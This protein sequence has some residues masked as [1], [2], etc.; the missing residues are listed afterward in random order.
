MNRTEQEAYLLANTHEPSDINE[1]TQLIAYLLDDMGNQDFDIDTIVKDLNAHRPIQ[2]ISNVAHFY[3]Y[4]FYVDER[5]LIPRPETEELVFETIKIIKKSDKKS[6]LDIGTGSG[7]IPIT[8]KLEYPDA[9]VSAIDISKDALQVAQINAD[10]HQTRIN[11][12]QIDILNDN[13]CS[14][15]EKYDIIVSNPPYIPNKEKALMQ[16]NVLEHEPDIALFVEDDDPLLYYRRITQL[17]KEHLN[18]DGILLF[19]I[20]EYFANEMTE[21]VRSE[22]GHSQI[23]KDLQGKD[24][25]MKIMI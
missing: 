10:R 13:D 6:I 2:Y 9:I 14:T 17:S 8:T 11:F 12:M 16:S 24:R 22:G 23:I 19:E 15:L 4:Q 1:R 18:K 3:G 7:V 5:V 21:M 25:M 20:N